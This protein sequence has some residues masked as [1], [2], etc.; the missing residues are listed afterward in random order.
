MFVCPQTKSVIWLL[1]LQ[2]LML[3][4]LGPSCLHARI[5]WQIGNVLI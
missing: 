2:L 1:D 3:V 5:A 4:L